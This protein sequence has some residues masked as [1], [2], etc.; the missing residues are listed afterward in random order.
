VANVA[1]KT[2]PVSEL[3]AELN[4]LPESAFR[5]TETV[6]RLLAE[7]PIDAKTLAKYLTWD[8]QHYTRNLIDKTACYELIAICWEP[9]QSSS[10]HNHQDQNCWMATPIGRLRVQNYRVLHEDLRAGTCELAPTDA[11]VL[12]ATHPCAVDPNAPVHNVEN[13]REWNERAVSLHVYSFPFNTCVVYS[14]EKKT[15]GVIELHYNT[16]YGLKTNLPA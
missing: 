5:E 10:V 11:L 4:K 9:G 1:S 14:P 3:V 15:C 16:E 8:G 6:H 2:V 7:K 12:D 13:P